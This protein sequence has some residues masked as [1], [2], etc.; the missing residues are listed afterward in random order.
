MEELFDELN[1]YIKKFPNIK[2]VNSNMR[3]RKFS[4]DNTY[5]YRLEFNLDNE[6]ETLHS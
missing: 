3:D 6:K 1:E 5:L 2:L 4:I